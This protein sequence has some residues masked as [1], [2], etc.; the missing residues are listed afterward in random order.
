M[1]N[2]IV[3][4]G[5]QGIGLAIA[6]KLLHDGFSVAIVDI[7][8]PLNLNEE[9]RNMLK[10]E[11]YNIH[12]Y[13]CNISDISQHH[14]IIMQIY[15]ELGDINC[16]VNNAGIA[17]RPLTDVLDISVEMFDQSVEINLRGTFFL[18]QLV[19][20][21]MIE[22]Q[23]IIN[24]EYNSIIFIT[25]VAAELISTTRSQ[26]CITKSAL[27]TTAK[28]YAKR[29]AEHNIHVHEIRPGFIHTQMTSSL[30]RTNVDEWIEEGRVP[31]KRWG[32]TDEIAKSVSTIAQGLLPF[33]TGGHIS[34]DGGLTIPMSP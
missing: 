9:I 12:Y 5:A 28:I 11:S 24:K 10:D 23:K 20:K 31:L 18:T 1:P 14:K 22:N 7:Q 26:Y 25:S 2:A 4:G 19:S 8:E 27:S 32:Q 13:Q 16:L 6:K 34:L 21:K 17:A 29:L 15:Q 30:G 33:Y 3:T